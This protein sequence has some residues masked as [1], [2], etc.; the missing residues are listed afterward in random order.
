[1]PFHPDLSYA[2]TRVESPVL[3]NAGDSIENPV[4]RNVCL[5]LKVNKWH[6]DVR[7]RK[8]WVTVPSVARGGPFF[9]FTSLAIPPFTT[10]EG[11]WSGL[12]N[13]Q[14]ADLLSLS[15]P[16]R[17]WVE[18]EITHDWAGD[19]HPMTHA[20]AVGIYNYSAS[21]ADDYIL[22]RFKIGSDIIDFEEG[23]DD[24]A[25]PNITLHNDPPIENIFHITT[26][27]GRHSPIRDTHIK[28]EI[29]TDNPTGL[30]LDQSPRDR[31]GGQQIR[32]SL[33]VSQEIQNQVELD[34]YSSSDPAKPLIWPLYHYCPDTDVPDGR[35]VSKLNF[36]EPT[37]EMNLD[38]G[39]PED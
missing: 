24:F 13:A 37:S 6:E 20:E 22:F 27:N 26:T 32:F 18:V 15:E 14:K 7:L 35:T 1:M 5:E 21:N 16:G 12:S 31:P 25:H 34:G 4:M 38:D 17:D 8:A 33:W 36:T 11:E 3:N 23:H 39:S 29:D 19:P 28:S 2:V 30:V 9:E 10:T